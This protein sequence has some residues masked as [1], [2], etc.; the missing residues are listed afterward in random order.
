VADFTP[1]NASMKAL[2]KRELLDV[3]DTTVVI[4]VVGRLD[5]QKRPTLVPDIADAL[6]RLGNYRKGDFLVVM[7]G[8]G[9]LKDEVKARVSQFRVGDFVR[10]LGTVEQPQRYLA[11]TD[12]FLLPSMSEGISI[13]VAEAMAMGLPIVTARAGALPEQLGEMPGV[14]TNPSQLAGVLVDHVLDATVDA[15]LYADELHRLVQ[16]PEL[17]A[18]FGATGRRNVETTFE[19]RTTLLGM[20]EEIK[21]AKVPDYRKARSMPNPAAH[22]A[23]Q[24][25][26]LENHSVRR[27]ALSFSP[28]HCAPRTPSLR[29]QLTLFSP[30]LSL[31]RPQETDFA[32]GQNALQVPARA[33]VGKGLQERCGEKSSALSKWIDSIEQPQ[34]CGKAGK[35]A[36]LDV[37]TLQ[38]SAKFQCGAW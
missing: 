36:K 8:D 9:H 23:L 11:A 1:N 24:N 26:L 25:V 21:K 37:G 35:D 6:R 4:G 30:L 10:L 18:H 7:L 32:A 12:V 14:E 2:A 5:P 13:A 31:R 29:R 27:R 38:R 28:L 15:K 22:F 20:F 19:W 34:L 17:R 33:G 3:P 16:D